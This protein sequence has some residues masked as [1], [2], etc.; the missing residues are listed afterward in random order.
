MKLSLFHDLLSKNLEGTLTKYI[1]KFVSDSSYFP[2]LYLLYQI[3]DNCASCTCII[4]QYATEILHAR[5]S[6]KTRFKVS[7]RMFEVISSH[8]V[9]ARRKT[10]RSVDEN[11][12][13]RN[14]ARGNAA[15][16]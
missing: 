9:V 5:H 2:F 16:V 11:Q 4:V 8:V 10:C 7:A 15:P 3:E 6:V 14:H 12:V 1:Y 13:E